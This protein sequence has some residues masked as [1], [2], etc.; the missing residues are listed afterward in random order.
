MKVSQDFYWPSMCAD[1]RDYCRSCDKCQRMSAKERV[2]P[3]PL[4]PL[5]VIAESFSRVAIALVGP[6]SPPSSEGHCY[7]V[8]LI[9][10]STGFTEPMLIKGIDTI[11][12]FEALL[13]IFARV[14]IPRKILSNRGT[15]FT[16]Q[17][18]A[19]L[20][21]PL[22]VKPIFIKPF[23]PSGKLSGCTVP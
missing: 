9:D 22:G 7:I 1:I 15:Q 6:L 12:V 13:T 17:L 19:E 4:Q 10:F 2:R 23:H 5:P 14:G 8:T 3:V 16:S 21:K 18:M 20:H 11:S